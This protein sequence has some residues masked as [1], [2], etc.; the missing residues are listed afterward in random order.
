MSHNGTPTLTLLTEASHS[1]L[2]PT[3]SLVL[4]HQVTQLSQRCL[5]NSHSFPS[6]RFPSNIDILPRFSINSLPGQLHSFLRLSYSLNALLPSV[7]PL[8][9]PL[10]WNVHLLSKAHLTPPP[11]RTMGVSLRMC[12]KPRFSNL[13][14]LRMQLVLYHSFLF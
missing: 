7:S 14:S 5:L 9:W 1:L 10:S 11:A 13:E 3:A 4:S 2:D 6:F 8:S 12:S